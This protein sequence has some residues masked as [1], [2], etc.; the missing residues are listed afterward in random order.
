M[1]TRSIIQLVSFMPGFS[2]EIE[3]LVGVWLV[4]QTTD[5]DRGQAGNRQR[6]EHSASSKITH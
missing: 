2:K 1:E 6:P 5:A 4:F 3:P